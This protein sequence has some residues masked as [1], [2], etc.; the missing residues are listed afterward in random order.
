[1]VLTGLVGTRLFWYSR[2]GWF[3]RRRWYSPYTWLLKDFGTLLVPGSLVSFGTLRWP[4]SHEGRGTLRSSGSSR[5]VVLPS[6][7]GHTCQ[8]VLSYTL[9]TQSKWYSPC[10][11]F[12][13]G[14]GALRSLGSLLGLGTLSMLGSPFVLVLTYNLGHLR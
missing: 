10:S 1:M 13:A 9:V 4:G 5:R 8:V 6:F 11:W 7:L 12:L 2:S 14:I 3:A